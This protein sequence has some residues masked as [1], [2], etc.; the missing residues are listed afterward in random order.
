[1][2]S[3]LRVP[4]MVLMRLVIAFILIFGVGLTIASMYDAAKLAT[5]PCNCGNI[6]SP[7]HSC[8]LNECAGGKQ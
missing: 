7:N 1:M 6:C 2:V 4:R 8:G 3:I 5:P